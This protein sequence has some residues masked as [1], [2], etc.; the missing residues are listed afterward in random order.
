MKSIK[1][2]VFVKIVDKNGESVY[3]T[4]TD[5]FITCNE[6]EWNEKIPF[7]S[8]VLDVLIAL[9]QFNNAMLIPISFIQ[10]IEVLKE[11]PCKLEKQ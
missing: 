10:E 3:G 1:P 9:E 2:A 5:I 4:I 7:K 8:E 11:V 6:L